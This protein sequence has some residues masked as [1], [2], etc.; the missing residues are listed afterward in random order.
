MFVT[1][2]WVRVRVRVRGSLGLGVRVRVLEL[3]A[4]TMLR[5]DAQ[6]S[7]NIITSTGK[8]YLRLFLILLL[9]QSCVHP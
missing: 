2:Y 4:R 7:H 5:T 8:L 6:C 1:L 9:T 3:L